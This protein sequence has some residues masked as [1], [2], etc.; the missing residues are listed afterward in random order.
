MQVKTDE[1]EKKGHFLFFK[2]RNIASVIGTL[3]KP[4]IK[5]VGGNC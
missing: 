3:I 4:R 5:L 1:S 2:T